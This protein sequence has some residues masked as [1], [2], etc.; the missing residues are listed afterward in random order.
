LATTTAV[1]LELREEELQV[2]RQE[3]LAA[4]VATVRRCPVTAL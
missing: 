4:A 2:L 3:L 1:V